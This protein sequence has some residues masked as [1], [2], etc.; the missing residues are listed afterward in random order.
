GGRGDHELRRCGRLCALGRHR[1]RSRRAGRPRHALEPSRQLRGQ[2]RRLRQVD[3][4]PA[5]AHRGRDPDHLPRARHPLRELAASAD[6][7]LD[8]ALGRARC[9]DRAAG[10]RP[11]VHGH[12]AD[13][14]VPADRDR[15]EERHPGDRLRAGRAAQCRAR[16]RPPVARHGDLPRVPAAGA[17]DPDDHRRRRAGRGPAGAGLGRRRGTAPTAGRGGRGRPHAQPAAHALQHAGRVPRPRAAAN[18]A[19]RPAR[20]GRPGPFRHGKSRMNRL[21]LPLAGMVAAL[22]GCAVTDTPPPPPVEAPAAFRHAPELP[23]VARE[24]VRLPPADEWWRSFADPEL[25]RLAQLVAE[26]NEDIRAAAAR[27][28][29]ARAIL[30][31]QRSRLWPSVGASAGAARSDAGRNARPGT[32]YSLGA[33]ASWE[34]D[35][36]GRL[37]RAVALGEEGLAASVADEAALRLSVQAMLVET[38]LQLRGVER[39]ESLLDDSVR[40]A[41]RL[42]EL[43]QVRYEAGVVDRADVLQAQTQLANVEAQRSELRIARAQLEHALALLSGLPPSEFAITPTATLPAA[44]SLP[45]L[46]PAQ[47]LERRPDIAAARHRVVAAHAAIG[48][49]ESAHLP[50]LNLSASA[51]FA[52]SELGSLVGAP[53]LAWSLGAALAQTLFDGGQ[54]AAAT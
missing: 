35:L 53:A 6:H 5:D 14:R 50:S 3:G 36:W 28:A 38:Y 46:L 24:P 21:L 16:R 51:G 15:E 18:P 29:Q 11:A 54:R 7:P 13:R 44:P 26:R 31:A 34:V 40:I 23:V 25:D 45:S 4:E 37:S 20:C 42:L 9:P 33:D 39:R 30:A 43:S 27:V 41:H 22:A 49:A 52:G 47:V 32:R 48:L 8:A 1:G 19:A 17:P 12:R 2:R 10:D